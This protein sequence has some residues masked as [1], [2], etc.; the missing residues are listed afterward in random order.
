MHNA[1]RCAAVCDNLHDWSNEFPTLYTAVFLSNTWFFLFR[2]MSSGFSLWTLQTKE[3]IQCKNKWWK[4]NHWVAPR[5]SM[6]QWIINPRGVAYHTRSIMVLSAHENTTQYHKPFPF[7]NTGYI[8]YLNYPTFIGQMNR[9]V[10]NCIQ[11]KTH[12]CEVLQ[13]GL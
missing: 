4:I 5:T 2:S 13:V 7:R 12:C 1:S 8:S 11:M 3:Y 10:N 9:R 6:Y